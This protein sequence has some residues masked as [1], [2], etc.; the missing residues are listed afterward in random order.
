MCAKELLIPSPKATRGARGEDAE[1]KPARQAV[2]G[3]AEGSLLQPSAVK[4]H[5]GSRGASLPVVWELASADG[6]SRNCFGAWLGDGAGLSKVA[7][8]CGVGHRQA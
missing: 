7:L 3:A 2:S 8:T 6:S 4:L 1:S 5:A